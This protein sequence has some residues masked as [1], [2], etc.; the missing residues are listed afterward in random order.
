M[1]STMPLVPSTLRPPS[2]PDMGVERPLGH[3]GTALNGNR[4][5]KTARITGGFGF[6]CRASAIIS[7]GH[8]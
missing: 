8:D 4:H 1:G 7:R 6:F 2:T 3:L 5:G